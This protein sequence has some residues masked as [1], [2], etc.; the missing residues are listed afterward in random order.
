MKCH[1]LFFVLFFSFFFYINKLLAQETVDGTKIFP[2]V[3]I[4]KSISKTKNVNDYL[5]T[6][7]QDIKKSI[8]YLV[9]NNPISNENFQGTG[10]LV[11]T[12]NNSLE[13]NKRKLYL[14]TA[15]HN[16]LPLGI[17]VNNSFNNSNPGFYYLSFDYE[18]AHS[19][20]K[21]NVNNNKQLEDELVKIRKLLKVKLVPLVQDKKSDLA[22]YEVTNFNDENWT[23]ENSHFF[24]NLYL[25]GWSLQERNFKREFSDS[26]KATSISHPRGDFKKFMIQP[27]KYFISS[28]LTNQYNSSGS[29]S[30]M[31]EKDRRTLT[32]P[33]VKYFTI[34]SGSSG[35]PLFN[36]LQKAFAVATNGHLRNYFSVLQNSWYLN[37]NTET[38]QREDF[39]RYLDPQYTW[40]NEVSGGYFKNLI[41]NP[42]QVNQ[43]DLLVGQAPTT[44]D[45]LTF[46]ALDFF[47]FKDEMNT[48]IILGNGILPTNLSEFTANTKVTLTLKNDDNYNLYQAFYN[49][50]MNGISRVF[51]GRKNNFPLNNRYTNKDFKNSVLK[52]LRNSS[53]EYETEFESKKIVRIKNFKLENFKLTLNAEGN[54]VNIR[55]IKLPFMMPFNARELF[56]NDPYANYWQYYKYKPSKGENSDNIYL[57][58]IKVDLE[59]YLTST[60]DEE[61]VRLPIKNLQTI[62]TGNNG[63]Y[64]NLVNNNYEIGDVIASEDACPDEKRNKLLIKLYF[65]SENQDIHYGAWLDYFKDKKPGNQSNAED[66]FTYNFKQDITT[67]NSEELG[68]GSKNSGFVVI[69][70]YIPRLSELATEFNGKKEYLTRLRVA[71]AELDQIGA[72][73][74]QDGIYEEG[75]VEDYL[76]R[77]RKSNCDDKKQYAKESKNRKVSVDDAINTG[78]SDCTITPFASPTTPTI[79]GG[80]V[81]HELSGECVDTNTCGNINLTLGNETAWNFN[82]TDS[83]ID[84]NTD[85]LLVGNTTSNLDALTVSFYAYA[86]QALAPGNTQYLFSLGDNNNG[87]S[88]RQNGANIQLGFATTNT[89]TGSMVLEAPLPMNQWVNITAVYDGEN[90][91]NIA[92]DGVLKLYINNAQVAATNAPSEL[93]FANQNQVETTFADAAN[94]T[95]LQNTF[96]SAPS[97]NA[98]IVS[99]D[100]ALANLSIYSEALSAA[101]I[102]YFNCETNLPTPSFAISQRGLAPAKTDIKTEL[103]LL[104]FSI[105]P[106]PAKDHL[107][108]LVEIEREGPLDIALYDQAGRRVYE[109]KRHSISKGHQMITLNN[110]NLPTG[111]YIVKVRA[112]NVFRTE[113]VVVE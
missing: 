108:I 30:F 28:L 95:L 47:E 14:A 54:N 9:W 77:I 92:S 38:N 60:E 58:A 79:S 84:L 5:A 93:L 71:V 105:F 2:P 57:N 22:L 111:I 8:C 35:G 18:L 63:G 41:A 62:S 6:D 61:C 107:N 37:A 20:I 68:V 90:N 24:D 67:H 65:S 52:F 36:H 97:S 39:Q 17:H 29:N 15:F 74:T 104:D 78:V 101:E 40:I 13:G 82:N 109:L 87:L 51:K 48:E 106:N 43:F 75:E 26:D 10:F 64:L 21:N 49:N 73:M 86:A 27:M 12:V 3:K 25:S 50:N 34:E 23:V 98:D 94:S 70:A 110:L 81:C 11:N 1:L 59:Q 83:Y 69:E 16:D 46:R 85:E 55:A 19:K 33:M 88:I 72:V 4:G 113:K 102:A 96:L 42:I 80:Q 31:P 44:S 100:G 7:Q 32:S 99:F 91:P 66:N 45:N 76:V 56:Q 89:S 103:N 53:L 112:G